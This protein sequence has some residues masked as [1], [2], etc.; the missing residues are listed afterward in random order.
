[1][2]IISD[3]NVARG[4]PD[5]LTPCVP[6]SLPR[7]RP[8]SPPSTLLLLEAGF[9]SCRGAQPATARTGKAGPGGGRGPRSAGA[10]RPPSVPAPGAE[11]GAAAG[12]AG[13]PGAGRGGGWLV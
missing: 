6:P 7:G 9:T 12:P 11:P 5:T 10:A 3:Q 8:H 13:G 1:M 4:T 2:I